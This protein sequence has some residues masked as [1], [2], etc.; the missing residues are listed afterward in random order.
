MFRRLSRLDKS[1][2]Q[3]YL[4][5]HQVK[6]KEEIIIILVFST[7]F[8]KKTQSRA[9]LKLPHFLDH[10]RINKQTWEEMMFQNTLKIPIFL[11]SP[12]KFRSRAIQ[13][14]ISFRTSSHATIIKYIF[15]IYQRIQVISKI[16]LKLNTTTLKS[17]LVLST[18]ITVMAI[19]TIRIFRKH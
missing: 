16:L 11:K 7:L 3:R 4:G 13:L 1:T 10:R 8:Q 14:T 18:I 12:N 9:I 15:T 2:L 5:I 6:S 17:T 19:K